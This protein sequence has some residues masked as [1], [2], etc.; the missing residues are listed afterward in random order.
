[1][2]YVVMWVENHVISNAVC[3]YVGG[4]SCDYH[5]TV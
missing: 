2:L 4:K 5:V 1:M 3:C